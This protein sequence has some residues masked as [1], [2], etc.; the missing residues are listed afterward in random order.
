MAGT[1]CQA[2]GQDYI[3]LLPDCLIHHIFS[4]LPTR[5]VV[6]TCILSRRWRSI[7]TTV[8][9]LGFD[10]FYDY[11][12]VNKVLVHYVSPKVKKFHLD[13]R[14]KR[15]FCHSTI[16]SWIHFAIDHQVE[17]L[18]LIVN[19]Y[20]EF[21]TLCPSLNR[22]SSLTKLCLRGCG[23]SSGDCISWSSLKS[24]TIQNVSDD[25]LRKILMGSPVL[26]YLNLISCQDV[27][28]IHSR[29]LRELVIDALIV[30]S[31]VEIST[32]CLLSLRVRGDHFHGMLRIIEAP[33]LV[34]AE[35]D[36]DGP[37]RSD[38]F[39]L[40]QMLSKLHSATQILLGAWCL[41]VMWPPKVEDVQVLLPNCK[42]LTLHIPFRQFSFPA[43]A[44]MLATTPNLEKLVISFEPS[45]WGDLWCKSGYNF[46]DVDHES[47][48]GVK[49]KYKSWARHLKNIEIIGFY[50]CLRIKYDEVLVLVKFL[51]GHASI[52]E[53]MVI[54]VKSEREVV[55]SDILL[56]VAQRLQSCYRASKHA[57]V[58]LNYM[59]KGVGKRWNITTCLRIGNKN[60]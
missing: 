28:R 45:D 7:W 27:R 17:D 13:I 19:I 2:I 37:V 49:K 36:F 15:D 11:S 1:S 47:Y 55:D 40:K 53:N 24:L 50:A 38:Y 3:S 59:E 31:L 16:D 25:V 30:E 22:C 14:S 52:L 60:T 8:L 57:A 35:L 56:E 4:F 33:F 34:I 39:P 54:K 29:S 10:S 5:E 42:S 6:K 26:E 41:R 20:W 12:I 21:Y 58:I 44:N 43:V 9:D 18:L 46:S 51:L 48:W 32:P 23:F